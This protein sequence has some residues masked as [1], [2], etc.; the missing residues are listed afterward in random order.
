MPG[1]VLGAG[2]EPPKNQVPAFRGLDSSRRQRASKQVGHYNYHWPGNRPVKEQ[3]EI[4]RKSLLRW[5]HFNRD[6]TDAKEVKLQVQRSW[7]HIYLQISDNL[8]SNSFMSPYMD[9]KTEA[10]KLEGTGSRSYC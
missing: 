9:V 7:G 1:T 4:S 5:S 2:D 6:P 8:M 3:Q 10:E